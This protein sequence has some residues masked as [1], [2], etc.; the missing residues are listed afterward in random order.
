MSTA[1]KSPSMRRA[2]NAGEAGGGDSALLARQRLKAEQLSRMRWIATS[3]FLAMLVLLAISVIWGQQYP[4]LRW[5]RAF[6]E[7][8]AVGAIADWFAV[9]ALFRHPFGLPIPHTAIVVRN[10]DRIGQSLGEFV[11]YNFLTPENVIGRLQQFNVA[12]SLADWARQPPNL[13][14]VT[15]WLQRVMVHGLDM[16]GDRDIKRFISGALLPQLERI[17]LARFSGH[18]L[19]VLVAENRHRQLL[20]PLLQSMQRWVEDF[21]PTVVRK[22]R[23]QSW[24]MPRFVDQFVADKFVNGMLALLDEV[25]ADQNHE[26]RQRLDE[27]LHKLVHDLRH[28]E[29]MRERLAEIKAELIEH[30]LGEAYYREIWNDARRVIRTDLTQP[31]S[32]IRSVLMGSILKIAEGLR[33]DPALQARFNHW[34]AVTMGQLLTAYRH[35]VSRLITDVVKQWDAR[36]I[37]EKMELEIGKDLQ[38]IRINGTLVGGVA[39]VLLHAATL[40]LG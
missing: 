21:R 18:V 23:E 26:L 37:S 13:R 33:A 36:E 38:F 16:L 14:R 1:P 25:A 32:V 15:G 11:E 29:V 3:L 19:G 40:L 39:G 34:L 12:A 28:S 30:V 5:L 24:L 7:A 31:E 9:V 20:D 35:E 2:G 27:G 10:K 8:A 6:A 22:V 4:A 17:D